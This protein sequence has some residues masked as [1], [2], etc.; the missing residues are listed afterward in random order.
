MSNEEL[1]EATDIIIDAISVSSLSNY[2]KLELM[3]NLKKFLSEY[4]KNINI[5]KESEKRIR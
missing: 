5:L 4:E 1:L 3:M 2:T